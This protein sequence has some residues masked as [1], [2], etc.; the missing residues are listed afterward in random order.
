M[1]GINQIGLCTGFENFKLIQHFKIGLC[2]FSG[3]NFEPVEGT[4]DKNL[5]AKKIYRDSR[6]RGGSRTPRSLYVHFIVI[7]SIS[8]TTVL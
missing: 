5:S 2:G 8:K 4:D 6:V 1:S 7:R 3:L